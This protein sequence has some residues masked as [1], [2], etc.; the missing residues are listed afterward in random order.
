MLDVMMLT[1]H[2]TM[3]KE[4]VAGTQPLRT[5]EFGKACVIL[6]GR[7]VAVTWGWCLSVRKKCVGVGVGGMCM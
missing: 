6:E 3:K 5:V 2:S 7:G 1:K 4:G